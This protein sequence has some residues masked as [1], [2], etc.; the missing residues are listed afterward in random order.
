MSERFEGLTLERGYLQRGVAED[1][2]AL[3]L[4]LAA[5]SSGFFQ[6]TYSRLIE[7]AWL[8]HPTD[9]SL[10]TIHPKDAEIVDENIRMVEA[11]TVFEDV[12]A[13]NMG[14]RAVSSFF[15]TYRPGGVLVPHYDTENEITAVFSLTGT[16]ELRLYEG[17]EVAEKIELNPGDMFS[18]TPDIKHSVVATGNTDRVILGLNNP[19]PI[20]PF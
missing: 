1:A 17:D 3:V 9:A 11:L 10:Q 20:S 7:K 4:K 12:L 19:Q 8:H 2:G 18:L 5:N 16:G 14:Q 13:K 15:L 6:P